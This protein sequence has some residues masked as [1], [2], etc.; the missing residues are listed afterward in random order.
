M[1]YAIAIVLVLVSF[2][3]AKPQTVQTLLVIE[4]AQQQAAETAV[5]SVCGPKA[6]GT[7]VPGVKREGAGEKAYYVASGSWMTAEQ[8]TAFTDALQAHVT[9]KRVQ[10]F[11]AVKGREKLKEL[12]LTAPV[13]GKP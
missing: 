8:I 12:K 5:V 11:Q 1:K 4:A 3:E 13:K 6:K 9:A 10:I 2:A 7:F